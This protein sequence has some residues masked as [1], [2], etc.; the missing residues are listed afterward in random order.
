M[1]HTT[2]DECETVAHCMQHGCIPKMFKNRY[3]DLYRFKKLSENTFAIAGELKY[4]RFG[5][6]EGQRGIDMSDLGFVDPSGGPFIQVGSTIEGRVVKSI[7]ASGD[8]DSTPN[9]VFEVE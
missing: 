1:S 8:F 4:W 6:K 3:G 2:C 7:S 5:G 9:I